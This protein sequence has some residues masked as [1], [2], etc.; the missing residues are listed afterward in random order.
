[1]Y[2]ASEVLYPGDSQL[3][4]DHAMMNVSEI[5][6]LPA[7]STDARQAL[8]GAFN[9]LAHWRDEIFSANERCLTKA[10]D[11]MAAAQRALGWPDPV[12]DAARDHLL[13]ASKMQAHMI[14]QVMDAWEQQLKSPQGPTGVPRTFQLRMRA[15]PGPVFADPVS[16]MTRLAEATLVPFRLWMQAAEMWQRNW[17][18]VM[19]GL[20]EP[21]RPP[22]AR[23]A[24]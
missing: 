16:E 14:D 8:T 22:P 20:A 12:V 15:L 23:K 7:L 9:A 10:L 4:K 11:E 2:V 24:A 18:V 17:T 1:M 13:K 21:T 3:P 6:N 5:R 19:S